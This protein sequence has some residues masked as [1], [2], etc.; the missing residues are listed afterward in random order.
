MC[1][2]GLHR[3]YSDSAWFFCADRC[4]RCGAYKLPEQGERLD[5][6]RE[7]WG[8]VPRGDKMFDSIKWVEARLP[9]NERTRD[10]E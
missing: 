4:D 8:Q 7:L 2:L 10:R 3:W 1:R 9:G 6:E 5:Q